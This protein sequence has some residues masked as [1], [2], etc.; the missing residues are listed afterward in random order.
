MY[1]HVLPIGT[2]PEEK[3]ARLG[4][5]RVQESGHYWRALT[6]ASSFDG[7]GGTLEMPC[8]QC[9]KVSIEFSHEL[10]NR[11]RERDSRDGRRACSTELVLLERHVLVN[12]DLALVYIWTGVI[13][14]IEFIHVI[15]FHN[16][17]FITERY[18][19]YSIKCN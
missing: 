15:I 3:Q 7:V 5:N 9:Q 6:R 17:Q 18:S 2:R 12:T 1:L 16:I 4:R 19:R 10:T 11:I 13:D 8:W 14:V